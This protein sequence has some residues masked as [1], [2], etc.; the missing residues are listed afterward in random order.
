VAGTTVTEETIARTLVHAS[1]YL[2]RLPPGARAAVLI[3]KVH[4]EA[5]AEAAERI[6]ASLCPPYERV[7]AG[8]ARD[9]LV[10]IVRPPVTSRSV[11]PYTVNPS[12]R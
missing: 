12:R 1:G 5:G 3:N 8:S 2:G 6:A 7:V 11:Q 4:T 9:G 10:R